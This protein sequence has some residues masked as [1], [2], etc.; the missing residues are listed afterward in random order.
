MTGSLSSHTREIP[1]PDDVKST[2]SAA[3]ATGPASLRGP[4]GGAARKRQSALERAEA[5][6]ALE[7]MRPSGPLYE[8]MRAD[9]IAGRLSFDQAASEISASFGPDR[10]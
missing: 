2:V 6:L 9:V 3:S 5:S 1:M 10:E 7:G 8:R 4:A